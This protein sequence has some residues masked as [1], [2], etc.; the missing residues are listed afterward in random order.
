[1]VNKYGE[2]KEVLGQYGQEHI[3][4]FYNQLD[5][6]KQNQLLDQIPSI[7]FNLVKGLYQTAK[8]EQ[9]TND[10]NSIFQN[11]LSN[12]QIDSGKQ[13]IFFKTFLDMNSET[14]IKM[15]NIF[16]K[17]NDTAADQL[18]EF[19]R[20]TQKNNTIETINKLD[21]ALLHKL[22][23]VATSDK[24][25]DNDKIEPIEYID[26]SKLSNE[27]IEKYTKIGTEVILK[28]QYAVVTMAGGQGT[29]LGYNGP[30]G[31]YMLDL[32]S[33][34]SLFEIMCENL[35]KIK[36]EY[37]VIIPWYIMTSKE[38]NNDTI[39]FFEENNYF[40][41]PKQYIKFFIQG[42]LPMLFTDGKIVMEDK[43]KIKEGADGH[44]GI[45]AAMKKNRID[46]DMKQ[47]GIKYFF[48]CGI[49][50]ILAKLVDLTF[51][52]MTVSQNVLISSKS[53]VK[54]NPNEKVGVFCLRNGRPSVVE[55]SEISD[56]MCN[57]TDENG[58]LKFGES[59]ILAHIFNIEML[60]KIDKENLP[61][62]VA[63]KKTE[64]VNEKGEIIEPEKENA[65]KFE[66]FIFD[67]FYKADKMLVLRVKREEE[68]APIKNKEGVD[69]P[70]TA[71]ELYNNYWK[72]QM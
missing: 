20:Q 70:Q 67:A 37:N 7:D 11:E 55:Y 66:T 62:H 54:A 12:V 45:F 72:Q 65:Y 13:Q 2:V 6:T 30:K 43:W 4:Q 68:F 57:Q 1:M 18:L 63:F 14:Q 22:Y 31:S 59:N 24:M 60:D 34:K 41:Y 32:E 25:R 46:E 29:R 64:Y 42:E 33:P 15:D 61:Y 9:T 19:F 39:E 49:D 26:K 10:L 36:E 71:K 40:N 21:L 51:I 53:V 44:G 48:V 35:K 3:L 27:D 69:S 8:E 56:E 52:G 17:D 47:K 5:P 23:E 16:K 28:N 38:N 58:E 50:N